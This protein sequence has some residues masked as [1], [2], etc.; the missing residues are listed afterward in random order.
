[1]SSA[2]VDTSSLECNHEEAD[3][4][5]MVH[6]LHAAKNGHSNIL[7]R[8]IDT[9]VLV[10][11]ASQHYEIPA[12]KTW[13]AFGIGKDFR[14]I[15]VDKIAQTLGI[16]RLKSLPIFHALT[17]CDTVS[18]FARRGKIQAWDLWRVFNKISRVHHPALLLPSPLTRSRQKK[19]LWCY[20][21]T[22]PALKKKLM[23]PG[24]S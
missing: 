3:T 5:I 17:S 22:E 7:I 20:C 2:T 12:E 15:S 23:Q 9:D 24:K 18:F 19:D 21:T 6:A 4:R 8:T 13:I 10:L 11:A 16:D 1:M 14:Y